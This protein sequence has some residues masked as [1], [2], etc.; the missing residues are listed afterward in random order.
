MPRRAPIDPQGCYHVSTRGN[1]GMPLFTTPG[2]HE[3]Y[4]E[5]Y[6][7][8]AAKFRWVTLAWTLIWNHHHFV[9]Q[10]TQGGLTEGMRALN[11][12]FARRMNAGYGRTGTGHLVHHGFFANEIETE[13]YFAEVCRYVDL[14]SVRAGQ[15]RRPQDWPWCGYAAALGL[16]RA[17]PFHDVRSFLAHF[18]T[19]PGRARTTYQRFVEDALSGAVPPPPFPG[20]GVESVTPATPGGT[21]RSGS[22]VVVRSAA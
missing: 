15:C 7:I 22:L 20:N 6:A 1:F 5:L 21:V 11:H 19:R 3:L 9:I 8:Q 4:L 18:G 14:N 2:E 13:N 16:T 17:R 10:L 12:G